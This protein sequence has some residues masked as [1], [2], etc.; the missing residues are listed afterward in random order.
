[1]STAL[2]FSQETREVYHKQHLRVAQ[3]E[4]AM[5]RFISMFSTDY[6]GLESNYFQGKC[7]L[8]AGCGNTGKLMIALSRFGAI[9][10]HGLELGDEFKQPTMES[11]ERHGVSLDAV[12]LTSGSICELPYEDNTFDFV[13]SHGVM[14]H[15]NTMEEVS[16][17]FS[18]L[19]RVTKPGGS[20]Y[21]V[22]GL[23]GG[24][25]EDAILPALRT[26]YRENPEF[27]T[28]IDNISPEDF[29][30]TI[31]TIREG[32]K[33][34]T[35]EEV[36][37]RLL[38]DLLDVDLCVTIQNG[39]QAPIRLRIPETTIQSYFS[40]NH[41]TNVRRLRRYIKRKN[42]RKFFAPLHH[43]VDNPISKLLYGSG[44]LEF[45]GEK[46]Q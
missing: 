43:Q 19:A 1:M 14:I 11:L 40:T 25:F 38:K 35:G 31:D 3:D 32:M 6:F 15:L 21:T 36:D 41:F 24:L 10:M 18:E 44:N 29:H 33:K 5:Q 2:D 26:Y 12:T 39:I 13:S 42:I 28:F 16:T 4:R 9:D 30:G 20:L 7:V 34:Y 22:F 27:K 8:D 45:I 37:L 46:S 17:A 23:V